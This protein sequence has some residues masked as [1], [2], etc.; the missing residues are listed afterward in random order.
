MGSYTC[1]CFVVRSIFGVSCIAWGF[2]GLSPV[3]QGLVVYGSI[4]IYPVADDYCMRAPRRV[5]YKLQNCYLD[6][7]FFIMSSLVEMDSYWFVR[8]TSFD[9]P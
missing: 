9:V 4:W 6:I 7:T 1:W 3:V 8:V 5:F 2:L